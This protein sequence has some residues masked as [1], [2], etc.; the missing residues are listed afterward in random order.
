MTKQTPGIHHNIH[1]LRSFRIVCQQIPSRV[2]KFVASV[3]RI[4]R[5]RKR[6]NSNSE[7]GL[8]SREL[9][10]PTIHFESSSAPDPIA[11]KS[12]ESR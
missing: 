7:I 8:A 4:R 1:V 5:Q 6:R 9:E 10:V 11:S 2:D 12:V 3:N